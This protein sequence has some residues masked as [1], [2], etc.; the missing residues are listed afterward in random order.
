M[1]QLLEFIPII[2][3]VVAYKYDGTT[4]TLGSWQYTFDGIF[5]ATA[6]LMLATVLQ[7]AVTGL[8]E[9]RVEKRL[10]WTAAAVIV[11]GGA[12]LLLRDQTFIQWKPTVFNWGMAAAFA[13]SQF[14]GEK[15]LL[16]RLMGS[17]L[18]LPRH[19]WS[20]VCWVWCAHFTLVGTLNL[21]VAYQFSEATWVDYK[22]Y[23]GFGFTL[24]IML[25]TV[26][27]ISPHLKQGT[28]VGDKVEPD[29]RP[30]SGS[31]DE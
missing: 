13:A 27:M 16:E 17:Q 7:L 19:I 9:R 12:T 30:S 5:S 11:F 14:I 3:F 15:N 8:V 18:A 21:V 20:K 2:L 4:V 25:I 29:L 28:P 6:I 1:K 22:L 24:L 31:Y 10:L 26:L 23:S